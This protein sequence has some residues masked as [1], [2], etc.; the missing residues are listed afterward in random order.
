M[1]SETDSER[2]AH[3]LEV[4]R[5]LGNVK[6][7]MGRSIH[8]RAFKEVI[9]SKWEHPR[10]PRPL[11]DGKYPA[12]YPWSLA[13]RETYTRSPLKSGRTGELV[14]EHVLPKSEL[15]ALIEEQLPTLTASSM[16]ELLHEWCCA[17]VLTRDED[18]RIT[19]AGFGGRRPNTEDMWSRYSAAGIDLSTFETLHA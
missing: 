12:S 5:A 2:A 7:L 8:D 6:D 11:I 19:R 1:R 18:R 15:L 10:L 9:W 16:A 4:A 14:I 17:V 3:I 13:A